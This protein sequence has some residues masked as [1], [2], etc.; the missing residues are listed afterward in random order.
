MSEINHRYLKDNQGDLYF[1]IT[2]VDAVEG[3]DVEGTN[4][5][6]VDLNNLITQAQ[7]TI[8]QQD[9]T[10]TQQGKTIKDQ[11]DKIK[12]LDTTLGDMIGDTGWVDYTVGNSTKNGGLSSGFKCSIRE[13]RAGVSYAPYFRVRT[14][15]INI[16]DVP[17]NTQIAQLPKGFIDEVIRF[18]P[19]V[20][21]GHTPPTISIDPDGVM[22]AFF[23]SDD[24]DGKQWVYGQYTW[25]VN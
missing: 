6:L 15:R 4:S 10:I 23:P 24:R 2:H 19:G 12:V 7:K 21:S 17:H 11:Q 22:K 13:V 20:S 3:L 5:S 18:V 14:V 8:E 9:K 1:P 25:L 16:G